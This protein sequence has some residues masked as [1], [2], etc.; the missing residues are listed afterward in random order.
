MD[1][2]L[3]KVEELKRTRGQSMSESPTKGTASPPGSKIVPNTATNVEVKSQPVVQP[4]EAPKSNPFLTKVWTIWN[5]VLGLFCTTSTEPVHEPSQRLNKPSS[6]DR[7]TQSVPK[8]QHKDDNKRRV[9]SNQQHFCS[10][11]QNDR[12]HCACAGRGHLQG[13]VRARGGLFWF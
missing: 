7:Q 12:F 5:Q 13:Q 8:T 6:F 9:P 4:V 2:W 1:Q 3:K 11:N 10:S